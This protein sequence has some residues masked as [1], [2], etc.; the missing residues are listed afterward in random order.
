MLGQGR[1]KNAVA[2]GLLATLGLALAGEVRAAGENPRVVLETSLGPITIELDPARAP[3]TVENFLKYVDSGYYDNLVFHRV[4]PGFMVQAGGY[5]DQLE[6]KLNGQ[7]PPI[8]NEGN[9]GLKNERGTIA[10]AR[11][12][13]PDSASAQFFINLV[14]NSRNLGPGGVDE[15]GYAVFGKVVDGMGVV[16]KIAA[17]QTGMK[18][19]MANVPLRPVYLKSIK[20]AKG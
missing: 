6:E 9:N 12:S 3:T 4:I 5:D 14:D 16:D 8:K 2:M 17:V 18:K 11:R 10:M 20:R 1:F 19:G 7:R 13:Q 15:Y